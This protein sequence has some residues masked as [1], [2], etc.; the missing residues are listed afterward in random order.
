MGTKILIVE[1]QFI[2]ANDLRLTLEAAGH[3]VCGIAKSYDHALLLLERDRPDIVLLDIFLKGK[4]TGLDLAVI[5]SKENI[6]FIYLSANS[7]PSTLEAAKAT[8]PYGFLVKPFRE[9]DILVALDIANYRHDHTVSL[10]LKQEQLLSNIL[11]EIIGEEVTASQK[12]L[13]VAKAFKPYIPFDFF[14][15]DTDPKDENLNSVFCFQRKGYDE[16]EFSNGWQMIEKLGVDYS[17]YDTWRKKNISSNL[18]K[19]E[20]DVDFAE[21][22]R[23]SRVL[24]QIRA[25]CGVKSRLLVPL[26]LNGEVIMYMGFYSME[27]TGFNIDHIELINPLKSLLFMTLESIRRKKNVDVS[28]SIPEKVITSV[29]Y[30]ES[31]IDGVIGKSPKLLH[32]LDLVTQV[33]AFDTSVLVLGE[34]GV[35]K[36]GLVKA[37][38]NLSNRSKKPLI[39]VNCA[40]I[41]STL[42][43]SELFGYERGAFT[44][45]NERRIGKFEQAQGG[46]IFLDEIG[47]IPLEI[48]TK[49]LRVLQEKELER[50]GG[51]T[52]IKMDVRVVAATN[53]NLH[54]D[55]AAGKFRMDLYYRINVFPIVLPPLRE[56]TEDIPLLVD[57]FLKEHSKK[58]SL[59]EKEITQGVHQKLMSYSWPGNIRELQH[60]IERS[61]VMSNSSIISTI[62]LPGNVLSED[63]HVV[64]QD[65]FLS[66]AEVDR[67]H[68]IAALK[69]SNGKVSG[70]DGAADMLNIPATTLNSKMKKL[71]ISW[72]YPY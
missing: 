64:P 37:I 31:I 32:S 21:A 33:A 56:R 3:K 8:R 29:K 18:V 70:K 24:E 23:E 13:R 45:A 66:I 7:N 57:Y 69:K 14:H 62:E 17:T 43:E 40:A 35:G 28:S 34:T 44:G 54:K 60:I 25:G 51:R 4:L 58:T 52:T 15:I 72:K 1:D 5:L 10:M 68:I 41:P 38:H 53:R 48:Q 67:A 22:S 42:I 71:G 46:T 59:P 11:C 36:E 26:L 47:E 55:V 49:L 12:L 30:Q 50:I 65:S 2:E 27:D 16:Y 39:K 61:V 9:K 19:I 20:G 63:Q 6:P